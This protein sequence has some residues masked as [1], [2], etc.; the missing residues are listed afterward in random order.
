MK[1]KIPLTAAIQ[2][3]LIS[4]LIVSG[5]VF[6][7]WLYYYN[8]RQKRI[9]DDNFK[10]VA[11]VQDSK[12]RESLKTSYLAELLNLS[13]DKPENLYRFNVKEGEIKLLNSPL[14]EEASIV[15][16]KPGTLYITY[17]MR[18]PIAFLGDYENI[19]IDDAGYLLPFT[20][21]FTPKNLPIL[22]LGMAPWGQPADDYHEVGGAWDKPIGGEKTAL[23]FEV[24]DYVNQNLSN[25]YIRKLDVS[26]AFSPSY[27]QREIIL[28]IEE[29][30]EVKQDH[31]TIL[32]ISPRVLRLGTK[33][34]IAGLNEYQTLKD[35]LEK[36]IVVQGEST[37]TLIHLPMS[38]IDLRVPK[39][40]FTSSLEK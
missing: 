15:K 16:L 35:H 39:I 25:A 7:A 31:Q 38:I 18:Q 17:K 29:L 5:S 22:N 13:V 1:D 30:S 6:F 32:V 23:A 37:E 27:G 40:A 2:W 9:Q 11:I 26:Q 10:I 4:M 3:I 12:D 33:N 28:S 8:V 34:Y 21:F 24:L 14:I 20:P 19:A 36:Q